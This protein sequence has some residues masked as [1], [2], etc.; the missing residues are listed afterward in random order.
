MAFTVNEPCSK[1]AA[2]PRKIGFQMAEL[3]MPRELFGAI[4]ERVGRLRLATAP[5]GC[6]K[7][8]NN[9]MK[10]TTSTEEVSSHPGAIGHGGQKGIETHLRRRKY[11]GG[12]ENVV[13]SLGSRTK[14]RKITKKAHADREARNQM[15][16]PRSMVRTIFG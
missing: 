12:L 7:R 8:V 14:I 13:A 16:N 11:E 4:L 15:G 2:H 9:R 3:A 5:S 10:T 6:R 1:V